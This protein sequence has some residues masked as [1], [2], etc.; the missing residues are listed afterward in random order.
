MIELSF[1]T[2][3]CISTQLK[4]F[5]LIKGHVFIEWNEWINDI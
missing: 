3:I 5:V 1:N 2:T 4:D